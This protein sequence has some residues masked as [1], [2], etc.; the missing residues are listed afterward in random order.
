MQQIRAEIIQS[1][2]FAR[3]IFIDHNNGITNIRGQIENEYSETLSDPELRK[4][5]EEEYKKYVDWKEKISRK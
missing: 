4:N 1:R 2:V 5:F 3:L